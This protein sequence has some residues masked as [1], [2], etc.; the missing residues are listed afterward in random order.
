MPSSSS[1]TTA[2]ASNPLSLPS[3]RGTPEDRPKLLLNVEPVLTL[4]RP[5]DPQKRLCANGR[6][7]LTHS[8]TVL[9]RFEAASLNARTLLAQVGV[10]ID[11]KMLRTTFLPAKSCGVISPRSPPVTEKS[12]AL[13]PSSG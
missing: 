3:A 8:T 2:R 13:V 10:S 9:L 7:A 4:V 6:S 1:T 11:G 5:S 12:G